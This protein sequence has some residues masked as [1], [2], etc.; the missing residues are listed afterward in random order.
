LDGTCI[1]SQR[2]RNDFEK[3]LEALIERIFNGV[4]AA[5]MSL[6]IVLINPYLGPVSGGIEKAILHLANE[7][8]RQ[9]EVSLSSASPGAPFG[10]NGYRATAEP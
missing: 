1:S 4:R 8:T 5:K 7:F 3:T 2:P 9:G 6:R 10:K